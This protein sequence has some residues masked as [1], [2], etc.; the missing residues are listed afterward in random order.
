M[1]NQPSPD[2]RSNPNIQTIYDP[3]A[4]LVLLLNGASISRPLTESGGF[5]FKTQDEVD[6]AYWVDPYAVKRL[7]VG[8]FIRVGQKGAKLVLVHWINWQRFRQEYCL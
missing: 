3:E 7:A 2:D 8:G 6:R 1:S 4:I 5:W